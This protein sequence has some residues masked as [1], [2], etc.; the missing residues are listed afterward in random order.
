MDDLI[1]HPWYGQLVWTKRASQ[2]ILAGSIAGSVGKRGYRYICLNGVRYVA[3]RIIWVKFHGSIP[4]GMEIDHRDGDRDNNRIDNL[5]LSTRSKNNCNKPVQSN[6][7]SGIKGVSWNTRDAKWDAV[8]SYRKH[9]IKSQFTDIQV[10]TEWIISQ[11]ELLH[12]QF[13]NHGTHLKDL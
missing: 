2:S 5:R 8:V 10:A 11:R 6:S 1:Y 13:T 9:K 12:R 4:E 3:H 7:K